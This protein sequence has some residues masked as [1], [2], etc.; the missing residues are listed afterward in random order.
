[1]VT[2]KLSVMYM[3]GRAFLDDTSAMQVQPHGSFDMMLSLLE[4]IKT[5]MRNEHETKDEILRKM[6]RKIYTIIT[7]ILV[8][9]IRYN[10]ALPFYSDANTS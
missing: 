2:K 5:S 6:Q 1:M 3:W 4:E 9:P 7:S 10:M 8:H